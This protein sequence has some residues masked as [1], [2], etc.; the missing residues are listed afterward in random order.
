MPQ[1]SRRAHAD[2]DAPAAPTARR[3][4]GERDM[5]STGDFKRGLRILVGVIIRSSSARAV[6]VGGGASSLSKLKVRNLA[7]QSRQAFSGG[8]K[9]DETISSSARQFSRTTTASLMET[10]S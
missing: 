2:S 4:R 6:A 8:E 10:Q 1:V 7:R 9:I 3:A 5:I